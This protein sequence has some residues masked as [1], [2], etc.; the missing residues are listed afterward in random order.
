MA[1]SVQVRRAISRLLTP[2]LQCKEFVHGEL[3]RIAGQSA[4]MDV[5]RF[6]GLQVSSSCDYAY[7]SALHCS[8]QALAQ[9]ASMHR[10]IADTVADSV[11]TLHTQRRLMTAVEDFINEGAAPAERMIR[12]LVACEHAYINT[13]HP[14]FVGGN[15][16][17]AQVNGVV[18]TH[19]HTC[20][21]LVVKE[22]CQAAELDCKTHLNTHR[23]RSSWL[24]GA[25]AA[26]CI[27]PECRQR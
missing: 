11:A 20:Q 23:W 3:L 5:A 6:P 10:S 14:S 19:T 2:A 18:V 7:T 13:D 9:T 17:I 22:P 8:C 16:A 4:P 15:R 24:A 12:D 1:L 21:R 27:Q 25:G 26:V